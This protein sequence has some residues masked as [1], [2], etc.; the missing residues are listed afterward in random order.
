MFQKKNYFKRAFI[1]KLANSIPYKHE[2]SN[3]INTT[4]RPSVT[5]KLFSNPWAKTIFAV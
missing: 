2:K 4:E 1:E 3:R 5:E